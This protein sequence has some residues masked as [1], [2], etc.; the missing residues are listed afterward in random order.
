MPTPGATQEQPQFGDG[1]DR[2]ARGWAHSRI[3]AL[4]AAD[5]DVP[6]RGYRQSRRRAGYRSRLRG[7]CHRQAGWVQ[8]TRSQFLTPSPGFPGAWDVAV[9][10]G[11]RIPPQSAWYLASF[12]AAF[13]APP[14]YRLPGMA[15]TG[16]DAGLC[17]VLDYGCGSGILAIA[18]AR[19]GA[20]RVFRSSR[21]PRPSRGRPRQCQATGCGDLRRFRRT[22]GGEL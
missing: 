2:H 21:P 3:V 18:A 1:F 4:L 13:G 15:G 14:H 20:G 22:G 5:A 10:H 12:G 9:W 16:H 6:A 11:R 19:L 7:R 17:T 8:L